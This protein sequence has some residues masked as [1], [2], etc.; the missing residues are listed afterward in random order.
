MRFELRHGLS[1]RKVD[2][3]GYTGLVVLLPDGLKEETSGKDCENGGW[4]DVS[5]RLV[6]N[7]FGRNRE[8]P[9][10]LLKRLYPHG[11]NCAALHVSFCASTS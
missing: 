9:A 10:K 7:D 5:C 3:A 11:I 6:I 4:R 8:V 1:C 2:R